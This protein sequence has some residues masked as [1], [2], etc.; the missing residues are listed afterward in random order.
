MATSNLPILEKIHLFCTFRYK[1][2]FQAAE[3][4]STIHSNSSKGDGML[5]KYF[6]SHL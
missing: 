1:D 4:Y 3:F 5:T 2:T 6:I